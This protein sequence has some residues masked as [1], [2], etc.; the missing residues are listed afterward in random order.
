MSTVEE[1][2]TLI[3]ASQGIC[4]KAGL[5]LHKI[6]S[7]SRDVLQEFPAEERAKC[8]KD[9]DLRADTLPIERALGI[10]WCVE[11]DSFQ[12]RIELQDRPLTRRGILSTVGSIYDPN[13]YLAPITLKGKQIL[14]QMCRDKLDWDDPLPNDLYAKWEKWRNE[15]RNVDKIQ[16]QRCF[17]PENF[18]QNQ[19]NGIT[20]LF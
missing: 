14:Q 9:L 1:A 18:W 20:S 4:A 15:I 11:N 13:G 19:V 16:I 3:K 7:N 2:V 6:V 17:K 10:T 12:F 8:I 5:K